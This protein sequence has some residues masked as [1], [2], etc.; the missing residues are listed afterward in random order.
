MEKRSICLLFAALMTISRL[1]GAVSN[2]DDSH[3]AIGRITYLDKQYWGLRLGGAGGERDAAV[4]GKIYEHDL[5]QTIAHQHL[6]VLLED[7]T[8]LLIGPS[9]RIMFKNW[10][11]RNSEGHRV[12]SIVFTTG[13]LK[14]KVR[15]IYSQDEPFL[16]ENK[17]GVIAVRGTE[18]VTEAG[19]GGRLGRLALTQGERAVHNSEIEVHTLEGEVQLARS[20]ELLKN[21]DTRVSINAGQTSLVRTTM[22][23]PQSPHSFDVL[24]FTGYLAKASP[25]IQIKVVKNTTNAQRAETAA[26]I[27]GKSTTA[28]P[29]KPTY[30]KTDAVKNTGRSIAS[31]PVADE[32]SDSSHERRKAEAKSNLATTGNGSKLTKDEAFQGG[33]HKV[34]ADSLAVSAIASSVGA[35]LGTEESRAVASKSLV[36]PIR[37]AATVGPPKAG[38]R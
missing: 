32:A 37:A 26:N 19:S 9:S 12:R 14:A 38:S 34:A 7:G 27:E 31:E 18:F 6:V 10:R 21:P 29:A 28:S 22:Q 35:R 24:R 36:S 30:A 4:N 13:M 1:A 8:E 25:G 20:L 33:E 23:V 17:N 16:V 15:K 11:G 2:D 5:I 3:A